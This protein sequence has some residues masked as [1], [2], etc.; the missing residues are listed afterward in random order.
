[1]GGNSQQIMSDLAALSCPGEALVLTKL[2]KAGV[3]YFFTGDVEAEHGPDGVF[4]VAKTG[5]FAGDAFQYRSDDRA[6]EA[7]NILNNYGIG[8]GTWEPQPVAAF[9]TA[10]G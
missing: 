4:L 9:S 2:S 6:R 1:M 3:R 10:T 5:L 8:G 7:A